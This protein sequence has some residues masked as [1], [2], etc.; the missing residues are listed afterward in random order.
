[1]TSDTPRPLA[2][3]RILDLSRLLPGP[4]ATFLLSAF[5]ADVVK[6]EDIDQG[7]RARRIP[8]NATPETGL[9][10]QVNRGKRSIA[11]NLKSSLGRAAFLTLVPRFDVVLEGAR[12]GTMER[13]GLGYETLRQHNHR[14]VYVAV[15]GY[16]QTGVYKDLAGHD[17]NY[18][19]LTGALDALAGGDV[20][21]VPG[22]AIADMTAA[23]FAVTGTLLA[24]QSRDHTGQGQLVDVALADAAVWHLAFPLALL[25]VDDKPPAAGE[26]VLTGGMAYCNTYPTSDGRAVAVAAGE[27]RFWATLCA[28]LGCADLIGEQYAPPPRQVEIRR[29]L[30]A[31]FRT[32]TADDW[33][34]IFQDLDACVTPI[35]DLVSLG[36]SEHF[37]A[38]GVVEGRWRIGPQP[39][40][41]GTPGRM[42]GGAPILGQHT[43]D[44]LEEAGLSDAEIVRLEREQAIR[45]VDTTQ[46]HD[47]TKGSPS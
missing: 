27:P 1:M 18:L 24:L 16:G 42:G 17:L 33:W 4:A 9:F 5:G 37:Q 15:S 30:E 11:I 38:R 7:D 31:I 13:L 43:R 29:R 28:T 39:L 32:R 45:C 3:I 14:L 2:G 19:A 44:V 8:F 22:L 10:A 23:L 12:P 41:R 20:P 26:T 35:R 36:A 34:T 25:G 47:G 21:R 46:S 6:V 40:L